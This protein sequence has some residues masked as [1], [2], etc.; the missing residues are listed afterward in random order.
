MPITVNN[1]TAS[2]SFVADDALYAFY[3]ESIKCTFV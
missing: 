3:S 1:S 2:I